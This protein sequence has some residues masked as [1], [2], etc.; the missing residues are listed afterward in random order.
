MSEHEER[1]LSEEELDVDGEPLPDREV[2]S[3]ISTPGTDFP[4]PVDPVEEE[5]GRPVDPTPAD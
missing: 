4:L 1:E 2:M 3:V 5:Y